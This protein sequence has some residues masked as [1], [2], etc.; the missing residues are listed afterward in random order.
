[1]PVLEL[2][3]L[4]KAQS[5]LKSVAVQV[6]ALLISILPRFTDCLVFRICLATQIEVIKC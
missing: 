4:V 2:Q 1:M 3:M 6:Q 5:F